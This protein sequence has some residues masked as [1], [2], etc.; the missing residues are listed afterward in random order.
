M[1]NATVSRIGQ[2]NGAGDVDALFLKVYA[3]EVLKTFERENVMMDKHIVRSIASG[4]SAQFPVVGLATAAYHTPGN[5]LVGTAINHNEKVIVIDDLLVADTFLASVDE[6]KNHYDL[7]SVYTKEQGAVLAKTL[8]QHI[9]Q[10]LVLAARASAT[11]TGN[12]GGTVL[13]NAAY[14][15]TGSTI[16]SGMFDAAEQLDENDI[17]ESERYMNIKPA[18]YYL[19]AETTNVINRDW[20][21]AGSYAEG[22]VLKV[23]GIHVVKTNNL[24]STNVTGGPSAYQGNFSTTTQCVY[25]K[26]AAGTVKLMDLGMDAGYDMRRQGYWVIAKLAVGHGIL[27][28]ESSVEM[29]TS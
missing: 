11:I 14:G 26:S 16:A 17:P 23:A 19:L 2:V 4:K 20:G 27:R 6:A 22:E 18:H 3:G 5:E 25:H 29:K 24:P 8:D 7:R 13:T 9:Q 10:I 1:S 15:T 28:P 12:P 21:G